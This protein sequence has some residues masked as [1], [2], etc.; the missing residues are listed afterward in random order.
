MIKIYRQIKNQIR[1]WLYRR[2]VR[3]GVIIL[4]DGESLEDAYKK[5]KTGGYIL[6]NPNKRK[7]LTK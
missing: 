2:F 1:F 5:V 4:Q 3:N 6:I 7:C